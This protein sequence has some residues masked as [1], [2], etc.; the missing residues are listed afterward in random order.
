MRKEDNTKENLRFLLKYNY[1][2]LNQY[3]FR[4]RANKL[5]INTYK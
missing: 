5:N 2:T 3:F 4:L 1:I